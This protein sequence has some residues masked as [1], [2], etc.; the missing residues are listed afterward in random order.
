ME[1]LNVLHARQQMSLGR[2]QAA[3]GAA[4]DEASARIVREAAAENERAKRDRLMREKE[5]LG[6]LGLRDLAELD[7]KLSTFVTVGFPY[8]HDGSGGVI[9]AVDTTERG[10]P[11]PTV[12]AERWMIDRWLDAFDVTAQQMGYEKKKV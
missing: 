2:S 5:L 7:E 9:R 1:D 4:T 8:R 6:R 11:K 3:T 10:K 12:W